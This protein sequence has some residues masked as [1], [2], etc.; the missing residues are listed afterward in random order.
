M[1]AAKTSE[2][3]VSSLGLLSTARSTCTTGVMPVPPAT[4]MKC[5]TRMSSPS[6]RIMPGS[7]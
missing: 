4:A 6:D 5:F 2:N 1:R 7:L 3:L